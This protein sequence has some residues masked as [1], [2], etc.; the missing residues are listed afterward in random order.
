[1]IDRL[2]QLIASEFVLSKRSF[3]LFLNEVGDLQQGFFKDLFR[4][5]RVLMM[6][7]I[8]LSV[9]FNKNLNKF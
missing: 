9:E 5:Q 3:Y 7:Y 4:L 6:T 1:M 8:A 2:N